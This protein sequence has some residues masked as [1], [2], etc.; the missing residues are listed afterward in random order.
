[1]LTYRQFVHALKEIGL[2]SHSRVI[3]H[4]SFSAPTKVF[5]GAETIVGALAATCGAVMM[6]AFTQHTTIIPP[7]G[8]PDNAIEYGSEPDGNQEI[9]IYHLDLPV[10]SEL[11]EVSEVMRCHPQARRSNHPIL[12]FVGVNL[13]EALRSQTIEEPFAPIEWLADFDGDVLLI[14][15]DHRWNVSLHRAERLA[16]RRGFIRWALTEEG[17]VECS[18]MPGCPDGFDAIGSRLEGISHVTECDGLRLNVV[19]V[20][21]LVNAAVGW[22]HEDPRALLCDRPFCPRCA[23]VRT[24]VRKEDANPENGAQSHENT[25]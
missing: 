22:I 2:D 5:G 4:S 8:P 21:D 23:A 14:D 17:V 1:M 16:G 7:F 13:E 3:A 9:E 12:S 11:G 18:N 10:D 20:R 19:P 25:A 15:T 6:P 24:S